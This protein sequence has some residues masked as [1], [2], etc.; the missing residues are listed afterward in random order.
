MVK[1]TCKPDSVPPTKSENFHHLSSRLVAE[2]VNRPTLP[3]QTSSLQAWVYM[4]FQSAR[5]TSPEHHCPELWALTPLFSPLPQ[6]E[7]GAVLSLWH[8]LYPPIA[9]GGLFLLG[10]A[11]LCI[12]RTFLPELNSGRWNGFAKL[13]SLHAYI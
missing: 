6:S 9:I 3:D 5:F 1:N 10:S 7:F 8:Y 4:V 13:S 2:P 11:V 12:V